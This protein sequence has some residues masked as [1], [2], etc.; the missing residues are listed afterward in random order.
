MTAEQLA[1]EQWLGALVMQL[2][3]S[4]ALPTLAFI[5]LCGCFWILLTRA[6][7]DERFDIA[8]IF[9]DDTTGK[10]S[11]TQILKGGA[12]VFHTLVT[13]II[14]VTLPAAAEVASALY[15]GTWGPT[16]VALEIVKRK[17]PTPGG[18]QP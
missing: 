7:R 10:V 9:R 16:A 11:M 18:T 6:Q 15:G 13:I 4:V 8:E 5:A 3:V 2:L 17:Y 12:F 14:V 1:H